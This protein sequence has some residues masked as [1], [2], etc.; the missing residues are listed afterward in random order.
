M[1]EF[2]AACQERAIAL[3]VLPPRSPKL[4]G[5]VER[6]NGT[7][8]R[9]FGELYDGELELPRCSRRCGPGRSTTITS[10]RTKP[11]ATKPPPSSSP[12]SAP[13]SCSGRPER[14]HTVDGRS[15][16]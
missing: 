4:N 6:T 15:V 13:P 12:R 9:E 1:A 10:G 7:A 14:E 8:R 2:E 16:G 11:W 5:H 3:F